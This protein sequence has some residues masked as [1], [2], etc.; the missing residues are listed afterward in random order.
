MQH[1]RVIPGLCGDDRLLEA[2]QQPLRIGHGQT[3][4]GDITEI[5]GS[6]DLH[7]IRARALT[8]SAGF[9]HPHNPGHPSTPGQSNTP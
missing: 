6:D 7:D 1:S 8:F 5:G 4:I 3:Q 2:G 9:H